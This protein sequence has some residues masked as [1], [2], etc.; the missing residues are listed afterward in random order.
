MWALGLLTHGLSKGLF[1]KWVGENFF[2]F[3]GLKKVDNTEGLYWV[4]FEIGSMGYLRRNGSEQVEGMVAQGRDG[5]CSW[6]VAAT[7]HD[8]KQEPGQR[9]QGFFSVARKGKN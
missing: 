1:L 5:K 2:F 8:G 6:W 9:Q 4:T 7:S 3:F